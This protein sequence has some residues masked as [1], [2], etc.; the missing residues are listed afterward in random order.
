[1]SWPLSRNRFDSGEL[2]RLFETEVA[3]QEHFYLAHRPDEA[4]RGDVARLVAWIVGEF[5]TAEFDA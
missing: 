1:V 5:A 3:T 2:V 4:E